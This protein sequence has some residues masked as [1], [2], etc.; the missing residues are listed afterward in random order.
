M[1]DEELAKQ[2]EE[3]KR[4]LRSFTSNPYFDPRDP[5]DVMAA[6]G[7][8]SSIKRKQEELD[9]RLEKKD[10]KMNVR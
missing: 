9:R 1:S 5:S 7:F 3:E 6:T 10:L 8:E 4:E 2:I